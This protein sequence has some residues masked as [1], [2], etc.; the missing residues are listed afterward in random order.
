MIDT[1]LYKNKI[2]DFS[3]N[4]KRRTAFSS[5]GVAGPAVFFIEAEQME[6]HSRLAKHQIRQDWCAQS[7]TS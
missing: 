3:G 2:L 7:D 4:T 1:L 5:M 6:L